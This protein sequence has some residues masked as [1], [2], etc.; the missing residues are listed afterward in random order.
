MAAPNQRLQAADPHGAEFRVFTKRW[1][2]RGSQPKRD[3][4]GSA[5]GII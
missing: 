2:A 4:L 1:R 3:S 5:L